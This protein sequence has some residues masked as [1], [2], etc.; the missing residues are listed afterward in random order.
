MTS[1]KLRF[2]GCDLAPAACDSRGH[3]LA[4]LGDFLE[5]AAVALQRRF[6]ARQ[7][8]PALHYY[9][10]ALGIQL[11]AV[12]DTFG[13]LCRRER[14]AAPQER[15]VHRLTALQVVEDWPAHQLYWLLG[16]MVKL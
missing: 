6:A 10:H 2:D 7:T 5:R 3:L 15:I 13:N 11:N 4:F 14:G 12:T 16:R 9:V 8:L 1:T